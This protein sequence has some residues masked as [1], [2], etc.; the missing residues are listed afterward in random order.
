MYGRSEGGPLTSF[1]RDLT[2]M[3]LGSDG[4]PLHT[5][6]LRRE[7]TACEGVSDSEEQGLARVSKS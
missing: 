5:S 1:T 2:R 6:C 3:E 4:L 7:C